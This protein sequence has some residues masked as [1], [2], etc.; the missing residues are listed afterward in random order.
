MITMAQ[1]EK[2]G[3]WV[4]NGAKMWITNGSTA[5]VAIVWAKTNG[6]KSDSSIRGFIVPTD[7]PG[8]KARDQKG[9]LSLR[10]S[11]TSELS[12]QDVRVGEDAL[13]PGSDKTQ[14]ER[15]RATAPAEV[16]ERVRFTGRITDDD[17]L[18]QYEACDVLVVPSRF[19]SFGLTLLEAMMFSKPAIAVRAGGMQYIVEEGESGMLV[20]AGDAAALASAMEELARDPE[21]RAEMGRRAR[22]LY[23]ERFTQAK[24]VRGA[25]AFYRKLLARTPA[26]MHTGPAGAV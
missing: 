19:E 11:D 7:T 23:E 12:L 22:A 24:M 16:V 15:F 3:S 2:D 18:P 10:A 26:L 6:D 20:P 8:F 13:L 14:V 9:K 4:I 25:V 21:R 1:E 17:L 5:Q